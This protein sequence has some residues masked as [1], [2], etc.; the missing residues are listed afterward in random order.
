[1]RTEPAAA[2]WK[3]GWTAFRRLAKKCGEAFQ[4]GVIRPDTCPR[5][6]MPNA[7]ALWFG[8]QR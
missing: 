1:M 8:G 6:G 4:H 3:V 5:A 7:Y 2:S